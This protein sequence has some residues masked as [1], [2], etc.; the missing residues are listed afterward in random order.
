MD[1][2]TIRFAGVKE[3]EYSMKKKAMVFLLIIAMAF[4][5]GCGIYRCTSCGKTFLG[6][7]Y[8]DPFEKEAVMCSDCA[9]KYYGM[10]NYRNW[11][12][13][14][15]NFRVIVTVAV[16]IIG[17]ALIWILVAKLI[18]RPQKVL[19]R[20]T[21]SN[22]DFK[23]Y[24]H[25]QLEVPVYKPK[26]KS[27]NVVINGFE[28]ASKTAKDQPSVEEY[29]NRIERLKLAKENGLIS[30]EEYKQKAAEIVKEI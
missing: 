10:F 5:S 29:K 1:S 11:K 25:G 8:G 30:E 2:L 26:E 18:R 16:V 4:L 22:D 24:L 9:N 7:A 20:G 17:I 19:N 23:K 28:T 15:D 6:D 27:C 3:E 13:P 21:V 12:I 14:D